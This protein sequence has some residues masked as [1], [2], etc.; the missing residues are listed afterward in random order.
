MSDVFWNDRY[1]A[2]AAA[3]EPVWSI[4]PNAWIEQVT[5][6]LPAGSAIDL[7]AGEGRNALWLASRGWSVTAV[8]F[9][10][11]GLAIGRQ[12]AASAG[13][14]LHWVTADAT[15]WVSPTPADLVVF[16]YLQLPTAELTAAISN[17]IASLAA[18]G[19]LAMIGHDSENLEHGAGG[20]KDP[21]MLWGLEAVR[22]AAAGLDIAECRRYDRMTADGSVAIDTIL[23]ATK[24][25]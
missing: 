23:L 3:G 22:S 2:A 24:P 13:L 5:G 1:A 8:D 4:E 9:A 14:E 12:R 10:S 19:T 7:A 6:T 11:A 17:A 18:G 15:T 25:A 21:A 20:P 16:A